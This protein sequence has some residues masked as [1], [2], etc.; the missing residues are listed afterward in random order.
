MV[1]IT[2]LHS[3]YTSRSNTSIVAGR[4]YEYQLIKS[5]HAFPYG[6]GTPNFGSVYICSGIHLPPFHHHG[7]FLV[8]IDSS[9]KLG[10]KFELDRLK[11]DLE[12][13]GWQTQVIYVQKNEKVQQIKSK[14]KSWPSGRKD[15][16]QAISLSGWIPVPYSEDI[17]SEGY[18]SDHRRAWLCDGYYTDL[19]GSWTDSLVNNTNAPASWNDNKPIDGKF[20]RIRIPAPVKRQVAGSIFQT[21]TGFK[22]LKSS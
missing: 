15:I 21:R 19:D 18:H 2:S 17:A 12:D 9:L 16:H 13:D 14:I 20:D 22:K 4:A 6:N 10:L 3:S 8:V 5:L 1:S 11:Q 7:S